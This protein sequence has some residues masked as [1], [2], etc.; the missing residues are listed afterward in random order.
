MNRH[1]LRYF[2]ITL[3]LLCLIGSS[4]VA[5]PY[6]AHL[7]ATPIS[8]TEALLQFRLNDAADV[9]VDVIGPLP[10][11]TVQTTFNLGSL[12]WGLNSVIWNGKDGAGSPVPNGTYTFRVTATSGGY[13][14]WTNIT[15]LVGGN[16]IGSAQYYSPRGLAV[17]RNQTSPYFGTIAVANSWL[18]PSSNPGAE[19]NKKGVYLLYNDMSWTG[20]TES[21]AYDAAMNDPSPIWGATDSLAPYKLRLGRDDGVLYLGDWGIVTDGNVNIYRYELGSPATKLLQAGSGNH[22]RVMVCMSVGTGPDK[23]L[24]GID[25]DSAPSASPYYKIMQWAIGETIENYTGDSTTFIDAPTTGLGVT[26]YSHRDFVYDSNNIIYV[27]NRRW[28]AAANHLYC[29]DFQ[30]STML[31]TKTGA[32]LGLLSGNYPTAIAIDEARSKLYVLL[33]NSL[34]TTGQVVVM[35]PS[36]GA[37]DTIF[38][39]AENTTGGANAIAVDDAGNI[40]TSNSV[41]EHVRMWSPPGPNSYTT[42][43]AGQFALNPILTITPSGTVLLSKGDTKLFTASGGVAPYTF[44][45]SNDSVGSITTTAFSATFSAVSAGSVDL[46]VN[47]SSTPTPQTTSVTI[48]VNPTSAPLFKEVEPRKYIRFELFE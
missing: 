18:A 17:I 29:Y 15:P 5:N 34:V 32:D 33:S 21:T 8:D 36:T 40:Y 37:V 11:T 10:V 44:A 24:F 1:I 39:Y 23:K 30:N 47:D 46:L 38:N 3:S 31:W 16:E 20:G 9:T 28:D 2:I 22:G 35:I 19:A 26:A 41:V 27:V 45:L 13:S 12:T 14:D 7:T 25:Q 42:N 48:T 43:Q 4:A 6:A